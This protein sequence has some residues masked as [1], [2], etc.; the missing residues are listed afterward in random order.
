MQQLPEAHLRAALDALNATPELRNTRPRTKTYAAYLAALGPTLRQ[1]DLVPTL[2]IYNDGGTLQERGDTDGD[3]SKQP[4][5]DLLQQMLLSEQAGFL[6]KTPRTALQNA[7]GLF[8][9]A[10]S[11]PASERALL[12]GRLEAAVMAAKLAI[13]TYPQKP[14]SLIPENDEA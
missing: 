14:L 9:Y 3:E 13:R 2:A 12:R 4:L 11:L 8:H 1:L 6:S 5:L 10:M 7:G